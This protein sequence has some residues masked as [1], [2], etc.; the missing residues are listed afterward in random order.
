MVLKGPLI[1]H[2]TLTLSDSNVYGK[3]CSAAA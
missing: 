3:P 2:E 1:M